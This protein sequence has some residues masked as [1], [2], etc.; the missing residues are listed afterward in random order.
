[1]KRT[2]EGERHRINPSYMLVITDRRILNT[3]QY[4]PDIKTTVVYLDQYH[5]HQQHHI[6]AKILPQL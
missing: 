1:M 3:L 2:P 4:W 6:S 5:H